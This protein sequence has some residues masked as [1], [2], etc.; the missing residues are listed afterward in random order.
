MCRQYSSYPSILQCQHN[1]SSRTA[2]YCSDTIEAETLSTPFVNLSTCINWNV[3]PQEYSDRFHNPRVA[4][5]E[6]IAPV[7]SN[8]LSRGFWWSVPSSQLSLVTGGLLYL[9]L[10]HQNDVIHPSS[11]GL[12]PYVRG[13][14]SLEMEILFVKSSQDVA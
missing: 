6:C 13:R 7:V 11:V 9:L 10:D 1:M 4:C 12:I 8:V 5:L 2:L 14:G 3:S